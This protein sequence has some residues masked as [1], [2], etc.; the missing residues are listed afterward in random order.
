M[1]CRLDR[2]FRDLLHLEDADQRSRRSRRH[3]PH[4]DHYDPVYMSG[5]VDP[6]EHVRD[7]RLHQGFH[8]NSR[9]G[10]WDLDDDW[11]G[12]GISA[13]IPGRR[14]DRIANELYEHYHRRRSDRR[15]V[16]VRESRRD[17]FD[18]PVAD[19]FSGYRPGMY[20]DY[21]FRQHPSE[22]RNL[23]RRETERAWHDL[24]PA[25]GFRN[26]QPG[27]Y[28]DHSERYRGWRNPEILHGRM[29]TRREMEDGW[30]TIVPSD[31]F[32]GYCPGAFQRKG[33][34]FGGRWR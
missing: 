26:Y 24:S 33:G 23:S 21:T 16:S 32:R 22:Y 34:L 6:R 20:G 29:M 8:R 5:A 18:L 9:T 11:S 13:A 10:Y 4:A 14:R 30:R 28:M 1:P 3:A 27:M 17:W 15:N 2:M 25:D 12:G 7:R 19:G 31:G